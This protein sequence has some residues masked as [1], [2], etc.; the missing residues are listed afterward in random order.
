M[1]AMT[2][3]PIVGGN[4]KMHTD[5]VTARSLAGDVARGRAEAAGPPVDVVLFPPAPWLLPAAE[6]VDGSPVE[7]GA[8]DV[9]EHREGAHTGE[10]SATMIRSA[11]AAWAIV[12]HSERRHGLGESPER[13]G[14]KLAEALGHGLHLVLCV[15]EL[16]SERTE[17][18]T[19]AV[20]AA[21]L[22]AA[23]D[24]A[25]AGSDATPENL[26]IAYEPVWAIGTGKTAGPEEAQEVHAFIRSRLAERYSAG[27]A[28]RIRLQYGGSVK[29]GNAADLGAAPDVDGFLVGGASL[30][31]DDFLAIVAAAHG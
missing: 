9:S 24:A 5:A 11:G 7:I 18:R 15:G 16:E 20:V 1:I 2:R 12:G 26:V 23:L 31:A 19:E 28:E 8:Q 3:T 25:D 22:D 10:V 13:V 27:F 14:Q 4:W 30:K 21:Q 6:A 17:G 29:P